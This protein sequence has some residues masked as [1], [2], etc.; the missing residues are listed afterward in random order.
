[1]QLAVPEL[2]YG[3]AQRSF[4][5]DLAASNYDLNDWRRASRPKL[6]VAAAE[7]HVGRPDVLYAER[8]MPL[9]QALGVHHG[10]ASQKLRSLA[11]ALCGAAGC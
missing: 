6:A 1:M 5:S 11:C 7:G 4:N 2:R 3:P 9:R 10:P 8:S